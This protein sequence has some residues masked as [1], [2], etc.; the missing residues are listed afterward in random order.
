MILEILVYPDKRLK[1]KSKKVE[2]FDEKLHTL[3]DNMNYTMEDRKG[4]GLAGIQVGKAENIFIMNIPDKN[5]D[6]FPENLIEIINP[7]II[8]ESKE[9]ITYEEGCLSL[10]EY[11]EDVKRSNRIEVKFQDRFGKT[12]EKVFEDLTSIA[13]QHELDHLRGKLFFER[14]SYMKR[15]KFEK[16]WKK[17]FKIVSIF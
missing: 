6:Q 13:F 9:M 11:Y 10:P 3:L 12:Q 1:F 17:K 5:G 4:I 2:K 15:K 7:E 14:I 8:S 16:D